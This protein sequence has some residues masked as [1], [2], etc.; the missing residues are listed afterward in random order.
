MTEIQL[1]ISTSLWYDEKNTKTPR[2]EEYAM[3]DAERRAAAKQFVADWAGR[4]D[5]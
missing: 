1:V 4:G 3:K 5:T 2:T